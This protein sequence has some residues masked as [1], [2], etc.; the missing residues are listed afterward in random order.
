MPAG[1]LV[2]PTRPDVQS[3]VLSKGFWL[4]LLTISPLVDRIPADLS[5]KF[6]VNKFTVSKYPYHKL[7]INNDP[8]RSL[9]AVAR[10]ISAI[11]Y[12]RR[13]GGMRPA[14]KSFRFVS[15]G[16]ACVCAAWW[17]GGHGAKTCV[18]PLSLFPFAPREVFPVPVWDYISLFPFRDVCRD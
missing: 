13:L 9:H 7:T 17:Y 16:R 15:C 1:A 8:Y 3:V 6:T 12:N 4:V 5:H 2:T 10:I 18:P 14:G 11:L